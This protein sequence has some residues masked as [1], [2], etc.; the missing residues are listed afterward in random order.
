MCKKT[1]A[2]RRIMALLLAVVM[3]VSGVPAAALA[4]AIESDEV[5]IQVL[6]DRASVESESDQTSDGA[7]EAAREE[8]SISEEAEV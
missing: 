4:E 5:P 7:R 6:E 8:E 2:P 3:A 1:G